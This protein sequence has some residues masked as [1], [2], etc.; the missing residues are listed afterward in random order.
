MLAAR[1]VR[2]GLANG[3]LVGVFLGDE[4]CCEDTAERTGME[5]WETV[6]VRG[7][8]SSRTNFIRGSPRGNNHISIL[9]GCL[10]SMATPDAPMRRA[11]LGVHAC[12]ADWC[13]QSDAV[14][15]AR[16]QVI[17]P[18]ADKF[19]ALLGPAALI[20]KDRARIF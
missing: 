14:T 2:P 11:R 17:A 5:C 18:V 15:N 8:T 20:C 16:L 9:R 13:L 12:W 19:R 7:Q 3:T 1:D 10:S 4:L 6:R